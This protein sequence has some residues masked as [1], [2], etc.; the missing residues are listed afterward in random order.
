MCTEI[1]FNPHVASVGIKTEVLFVPSQMH[2]PTRLR[3]GPSTVHEDEQ[4]QGAR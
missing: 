3:A 4:R 1:G 2:Q